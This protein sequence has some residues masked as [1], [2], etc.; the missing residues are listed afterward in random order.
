MDVAGEQ[1]GSAVRRSA[2][3]RPLQKIEEVRR[4]PP[5]SAAS[6]MRR[7][8]PHQMVDCRARRRTGR[9]RSATS[10]GSCRRNRDPRRRARSAARPRRHDAGRGAHDVGEALARI[11]RLAVGAAAPSVPMPPAWASMS[12][13]P[14]GVPAA[15][16]SS[17]AAAAL[18]PSPSG[19]PG[20][21][22]SRADRAQPSATSRPGRCARNSSGS[23]AS[24]APDRSICRSR[25]QSERTVVPVARNDR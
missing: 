21:T 19:V 23:S 24:H 12:E 22:I 15:R 18:S 5:A 11:D 13:A 25:V 20:S 14:T 8:R 4:R 7:M 6:A 1:R 16:P 2:P 17:A 10:P 3:G 9:P